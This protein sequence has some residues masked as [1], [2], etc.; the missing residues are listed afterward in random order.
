VTYV[1]RSHIGLQ[2]KIERDGKVPARKT[3]AQHFYDR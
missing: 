3:L 1:Q 2:E